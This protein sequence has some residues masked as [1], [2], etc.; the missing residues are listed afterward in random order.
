MQIQ[1]EFNGR[2]ISPISEQEGLLSLG[3]AEDT[4]LR[5]SFTTHW[6]PLLAHDL[7]NLL[8]SNLSEL[9]E[10]ADL[11]CWH[12]PFSEDNNSTDIP[13]H[14]DCF[15]QSNIDC[16]Y[17][18]LTGVNQFYFQEFYDEF[19]DVILTFQ[20]EVDATMANPVRDILM[21]YARNA[22]YLLYALLACGARS[23]YRK[24]H[25]SDDQISYKFYLKRCLT[26]L[27]ETMEEDIMSNIDSILLTIMVLTCDSAS[28]TCQG[29][30]PHL[31]SASQLLLRVGVERPYSSIFLLC[32][33]WFSSIEILAG[34]ASPSGGVFKSD[35]EL[36]QMIVSH[37]DGQLS[38]LQ[39]LHVITKEGFSLFH[40][41]SLEMLA[42]LKDLIKVIRRKEKTSISYGTVLD[43]ISRAQNELH[44]QVID[45]GG[46][47][48]ESH[49]SYNKL[50]SIAHKGLSCNVGVT[51]V[52]GEKIALSWLDISNRCYALAALVTIFTR[53]LN[54][55]KGNEMIQSMVKEIFSKACYFEDTNSFLKSNCFF[56]LQWPMLIAGT[57]V[58]LEEDKLRVE[59]FFRLVAQ[60][61]SGSAGF[62]LDRLRKI[63]SE[64]EAA[65]AAEIHNSVDMVT[66]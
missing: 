66:Y 64:G 5:D 17:L 65:A 13:T 7:S 34:L 52:N 56:V 44:F 27:S 54:V 36:D 29:W 33:L 19:S 39:Q 9:T 10:V 55:D 32:K 59:A 48:H 31:Q 49:P 41:Y 53:L 38:I 22:Y 61:G 50:V 57:N 58:V 46:I 23:S 30:R 21:V 47:I 40:G 26:T 24:S 45:N 28:H 43:L 1:D 25:L 14:E 60:L 62:S 8:N 12:S 63:W 11:T 51:C 18:N 42:I 16:H 2:Q 20:A 4:S 15:F 37:S 6:T 35:E 3:Q